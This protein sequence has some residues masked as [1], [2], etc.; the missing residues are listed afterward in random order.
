MAIA[1][2]K[3]V[4]TT[5]VPSLVKEA[6]VSGAGWPYEFLAPT[7]MIAIWADKALINC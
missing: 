2:S 1:P 3:S 4:R 5:C 7:L 6:I